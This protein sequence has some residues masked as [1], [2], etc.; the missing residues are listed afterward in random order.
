MR[1]PQRRV[2]KMQIGISSQVAGQHTARILQMWTTGGPE[3]TP[4]HSQSGWRL[5]VGK[6][7]AVTGTVGIISSLD[8]TSD[9][10]DPGEEAR[11][12]PHK[13]SVPY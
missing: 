12:I 6:V 2:P 7:P 11:K 8:G 10:M 9:Q 4:F 13:Y 3:M 5:M 1:S